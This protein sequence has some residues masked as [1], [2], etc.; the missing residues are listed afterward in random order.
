MMLKSSKSFTLS[1]SCIKDEWRS[2]S[3]STEIKIQGYL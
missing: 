2:S 3:W 1:W